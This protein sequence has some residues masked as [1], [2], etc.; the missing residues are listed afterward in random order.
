ME[1]SSWI[2][3]SLA[4]PNSSP[5][6]TVQQHSA[7]VSLALPQLN[8]SPFRAKSRSSSEF[9]YYLAP[10]SPSW[11]RLFGWRPIPC[12]LME[13]TK[14]PTEPGKKSK[15]GISR[16]F[17]RG[18]YAQAQEKYGKKIVLCMIVVC[19]YTLG[20]RMQRQ[21]TTFAVG[22]TKKRQKP[23]CICLATCPL[24]WTFFTSK[25]GSGGPLLFTPNK[26]GRKP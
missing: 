7:P 16:T 13:L 15:R 11:P 8:Q 19:S 3:V 6:I 9:P 12:R 23:S 5:H 24:F 10:P 25:V 26:N 17:E 20:M 18:I 4:H 21:P 14:V 22:I 1:L 2:L